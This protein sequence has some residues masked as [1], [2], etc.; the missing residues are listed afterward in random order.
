MLS[1]IKCQRVGYVEQDTLYPEPDN[2]LL[3]LHLILLIILLSISITCYTSFI[4]YQRGE[5]LFPV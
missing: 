3:P 5:L 2:S 1:L 4:V